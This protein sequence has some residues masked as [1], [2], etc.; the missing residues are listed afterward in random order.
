MAM[1]TLALNHPDVVR[2]RAEEREVLKRNWCGRGRQMY[3]A[4]K[5]IGELQRMLWQEKAEIKPIGRFPLE[6]AFSL[7]LHGELVPRQCWI[8]V[9]DKSYRTIYHRYLKQYHGFPRDARLPTAIAVDHVLNR[10]NAIRSKFQNYVLL[11]MVDCE[12]NSSFGRIYE[13]HIEINGRA[14]SPVKEFG[15]VIIDDSDWEPGPG[16]DVI[17]I[18]W[19]LMIKVFAEQA[20]PAEISDRYILRV[21]RGFHQ[22]GMLSKSELNGQYAAMAIIF[23]AGVP[24]WP[25]YDAAGRVPTETQQIGGRILTAE[26]SV[27][28]WLEAYAV[29]LGEYT[30]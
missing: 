8:S 15:G 26:L 12:I 13:R 25:L 20:P 4:A 3:I 5:G 14:K 29:E 6:R 11:T 27:R 2:V 16:G 24:G 17:S 23:R 10:Q 1:R 18:N 9:D 7:S 21:L 30:L 19:P 22:Q 28:T